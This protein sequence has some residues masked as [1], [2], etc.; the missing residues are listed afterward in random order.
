MAEI[1]EQWLPEAAWLMARRWQLVLVTSFG[2]ATHAT[3]C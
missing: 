2:A 3:E 1:A